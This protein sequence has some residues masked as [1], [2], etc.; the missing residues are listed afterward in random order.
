MSQ[1]VLVQCPH[2][3]AEGNLADPALFGQAISCPVC[4]QVF[5]APFPTASEPIASVAS[6]SGDLVAAPGGDA[7]V[8]TPVPP[9]PVDVVQAPSAVEPVTTAVT[10]EVFATNDMTSTATLGGSIPGEAPPVENPAVAAVPVA[11][12]PAAAVIES[13]AVIP[14]EQLASAVPAAVSVAAEPVVPAVPPAINPAMPGD[15]V[16]AT[17]FAIT[18]PDGQVVAVQGTAQEVSVGALPAVGLPAMPV[19][20]APVVAVVPAAVSTG[21]P[22][23]IQPALAAPVEP[24][25]GAPGP[26]GPV[27]FPGQVAAFPP[28]VALPQQGVFIPPP[29]E[30]TFDGPLPA[31]LAPAAAPGADEMRFAESL[32]EP[33]ARGSVKPPK[34]PSKSMQTIIISTITVILLFSTVMFLMGDPSRK[35]GKKPKSN[36]SEEDNPIARPLD[37]GP[38]DQSIEDVF[39]RINAASGSGNQKNDASKEKK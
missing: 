23:S 9:P 12:T 15:L 20:P 18:P 21:I 30:H 16:P 24:A 25:A 10:T 35:F 29:V 26:Q 1:S 34:A 6:V 33:V 2:C 5:T 14:P 39:A 17:Q 19:S 13:V 28:A 8:A 11:P 31:F 38:A 22:A 4:Q 7:N 32:P 37:S 27:T 3:R 36:Q